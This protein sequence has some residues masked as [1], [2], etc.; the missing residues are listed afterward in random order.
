[1]S[2]EELEHW[3]WKAY[4]A[5]L[6]DERKGRL[7]SDPYRELSAQNR[8]QA[9]LEALRETAKVNRMGF[10]VDDERCSDIMCRCNDE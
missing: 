5:A 2:V 4:N 7:L 3:L 1:M 10:G 8:A 6:E 9:F